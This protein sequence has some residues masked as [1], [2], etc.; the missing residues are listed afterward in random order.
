MLHIM[1]GLKIYRKPKVKK[2]VDCKSLCSPQMA[3]VIIQLHVMTGRD[4]NSAFFGHGKQNIF[5]K[6]QGSEG[7]RNLLKFCGVFR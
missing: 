2:F 5:N 6:I 1:P 7:A 4:S 3:E